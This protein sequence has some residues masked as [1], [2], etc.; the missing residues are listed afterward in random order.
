MQSEIEARDSKL[1]EIQA[2]V[3]AKE[4]AYD[5]SQRLLAATQKELRTTMESLQAPVI[6]TSQ[7]EDKQMIRARLHAVKS[8]G[9][10]KKH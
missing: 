1:Q 8:L 10:V 5:E 6:I 2:E 9:L 4:E 3:R 7:E